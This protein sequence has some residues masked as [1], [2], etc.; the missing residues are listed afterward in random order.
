MVFEVSDDGRGID[1]AAIRALA[2]RWGLPSDT[3]QQQ[4][5][6]FLPPNSPDL[7]RMADAWSKAMS[8]LRVSAAR[9]WGL[10][11]RRPGP[12]RV[13]NAGAKERGQPE[14]SGASAAPASLVQGES[15]L[16]RTIASPDVAR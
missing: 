6:K 4:G 12:A 1:W 7:N 2:K 11:A 15:P 16:R 8:R 13:T 10:G 5:S 9:T 3:Q 14:C